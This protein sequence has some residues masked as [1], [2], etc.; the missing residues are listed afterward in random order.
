MINDEIKQ[1]KKIRDKYGFPIWL[2]NEDLK[3]YDNDESK[4]VERLK[5]IYN[6]IGDHPNVVVKRNI[7]KFMKEIKH[8]KAERKIDEIRQY[9]YNNL[10]PLVSQDSWQVYG[11]L[12]D[13]IDELGELLSNE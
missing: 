12:I 5:E 3:Y 1:I 11:D 6:V 9:L 8:R 7:E 10:H 2:I 4:T 13:M